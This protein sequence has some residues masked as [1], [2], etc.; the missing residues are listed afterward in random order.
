[1][2]WHCNSCKRNFLRDI[3]AERTKDIIEGKPKILFCPYCNSDKIEY[4]QN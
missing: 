2:T 4:I 1:M 3:N